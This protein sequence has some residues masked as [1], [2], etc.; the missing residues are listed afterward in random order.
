MLCQI[1]NYP[2]V[3]TIILDTFVG[4]S[5]AYWLRALLVVCN[6]L[7]M[8]MNGQIS[9]RAKPGRPPSRTPANSSVSKRRCPS[10]RVHSVMQKPI[11]ACHQL[12]LAARPFFY[13]LHSVQTTSTFDRWGS[14]QNR[15]SKTW[16]EN[17]AG[18]PSLLF[19]LH[20]PFPIR[21]SGGDCAVFWSPEHAEKS[22]PPWFQGWQ[23][24]MLHT[25]DSLI[26]RLK[27]AQVGTL[28]YGGT[29]LQSWRLVTLSDGYHDTVAAIVA[30]LTMVLVPSRVA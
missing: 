6:A 22:F 28:P 15:K 8:P 9:R 4:V 26:G 13:P 25:R 5:I 23:C 17:A 24:Q 12:S 29:L 7:S 3:C 30:S 1:G 16:D 14:D 18:H 20:Q 21:S 27:S 2:R 11:T 19:Q 10:V